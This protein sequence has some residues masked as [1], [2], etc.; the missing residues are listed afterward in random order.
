MLNGAALDRESIREL[1]ESPPEGQPPLVEELL[2][3]DEQLQPTGMDFSLK[4]VDRLTS[5][6]CMGRDAADRSLPLSETMDFGNDGW[7]FLNTGPYLVTFNEIVNIPLNIMALARPRSS[8]I[9]SGVSLH[10]AVWDAGYRGR[11]Q[12]LLSVLN[13][14]GYHL[15][16]DARLMQMIF[17]RLARPVERGYQGRYQGERP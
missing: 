15:Q 10:T 14:A 1:V 12:A 9:R 13:P 11:S 3:L 2:S 5:D 6:G 17:F 8:L 7:L 16:R 4:R